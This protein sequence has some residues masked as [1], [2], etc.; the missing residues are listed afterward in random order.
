MLPEIF[1]R[2][3]PCLLLY[4]CSGSTSVFYWLILGETSGTELVGQSLMYLIPLNSLDLSHLNS[5][6][7]HSIIHN[8]CWFPKES[9]SAITSFNILQ[10]NWWRAS[11]ALRCEAWYIH[12]FPQK[13][14]Y[15]RMPLLQRVE[16]SYSLTTFFVLTSWSLSLY[17]VSWCEVMWAA[18]LQ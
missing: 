4:V 3:R 14:G 12:F 11:V 13:M 7:S 5:T 17:T 18:V 1:S 2:R 8:S 10:L 6:L 16:T 9:A 15:Y